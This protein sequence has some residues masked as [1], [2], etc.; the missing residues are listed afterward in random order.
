MKSFNAV[1]DVVESWFLGDGIPWHFLREMKDLD[2]FSDQLPLVGWVIG[3]DEILPS[4]IGITL[5]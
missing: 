1:V 5:R 3:G 2:L 4:Y